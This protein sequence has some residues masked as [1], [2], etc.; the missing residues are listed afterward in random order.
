MIGQNAGFGNAG[1]SSMGAGNCF[2]QFN[3]FYIL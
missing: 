3:T 1:V 2:Y